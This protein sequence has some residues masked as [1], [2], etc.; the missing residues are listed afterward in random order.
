MFKKMFQWG[1]KNENKFMA[2]TIDGKMP[3]FPIPIA[4][5]DY[6]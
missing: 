6:E 4:E 3:I 5:D 1:T 2:W